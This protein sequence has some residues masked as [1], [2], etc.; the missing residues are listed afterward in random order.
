MDN[1]FLEI[2]GVS[3]SDFKVAFYDEKDVCHYE[4]TIKSNNWVKVNR[5]YYTKWTAKVWQ[6]GELIYENTLDLHNKKSLHSL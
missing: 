2:K 1:P 5:Q 4:N 6:D 3:D